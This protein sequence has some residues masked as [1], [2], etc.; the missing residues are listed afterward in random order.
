[1]PSA[2]ASAAT[3]TPTCTTAR[4]R[5]CRYPATWFLSSG[6]ESRRRPLS[7]HPSVVPFQFF[8]TADGH[9]A[10]ACPKEKFF[11]ALVRVMGLPEL[12][13]DERFASFAARGKHRDEVVDRLSGRFAELTTA[14]WLDMLRGVVPVAPV[15]SLSQALD[16]DELQARG[17]LAEY[18]DEAFGRVRS[19][20]LPLHVG[21]FTPEYRAGPGLGADLDAILDELGYDATAVDRLRAA[22]AFGD[23]TGGAPG[24]D[25]AEV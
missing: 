24:V 7:A 1:M 3:S 15:R 21:G 23:A 17:M 22:G 5:C 4:S 16:V 18:E 11:T 12:A 19:V 8:A 20:G 13:T 2:P 14:Q 25:P 9:I 10:I 6:F